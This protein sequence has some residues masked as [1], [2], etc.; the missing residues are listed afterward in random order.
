MRLASAP[1]SFWPAPRGWNNKAVAARLAGNM[2]TVGKWRRRFL[3]D[4]L[5][6]LADEPPSGALRKI[7]DEVVERVII[8]TLEEKPKA[9]TH[10]SSRGM[11]EA[12]GLPQNAISRVWRAFGL[13]PHLS[14]RFKLSTDPFFVAKVRDVSGWT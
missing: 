8:K 14:E 11:A 1:V 7:T 3:D 13:K 6:G 2:A 4:S 9:A 5:D 10:W 12:V